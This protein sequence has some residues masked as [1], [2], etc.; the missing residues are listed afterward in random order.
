MFTP[1]QISNVSD[2]HVPT[3]SPSSGLWKVG[4]V[5][6]GRIIGHSPLDALLYLSFKQS[7][8]DQKFFKV[9]DVQVGQM[10]KGTIHSLTDSALF[11][12]IAG[13][14]H[15]VVWPNHFADIRLKHPE[16]KFKI[17]SSIKC[18]VG[19]LHLRGRTLP[20]NV[21]GARCRSGE[22]PHM[23]YCKKDF[24]RVPTAHHCKYCRCQSWRV[25]TCCRVQG[26]RTGALCRVLQQCQGYYTS[27]RSDVSPIYCDTQDLDLLTSS[28]VTRIL[29]HLR[30]FL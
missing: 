21:L 5:H 28:P 27:S 29:A 17:G 12:A 30:G 7:V 15:A 23:P 1:Y 8:L 13:N 2:E 19:A 6:R 18:R 25:S 16:R 22:E 3:L 10:V 26:L 4:T 9:T 11:V 14:M 24:A 20:I